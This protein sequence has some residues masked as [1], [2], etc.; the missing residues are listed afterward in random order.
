MR[1][2]KIFYLFIHERHNRERGRETGRGRS[3]LHAWS[4]MRDSIPELLDHALS[5]KQTLNHW[6]T[7]VSLNMRYLLMVR[8]TDYIPQILLWKIWYIIPDW[9]YLVE[10]NFRLP[11]RKFTFH[12]CQ[13]LNHNVFYNTGQTIH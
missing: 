5:Q 7:Q 12:K 2:L 10:K 3:R 11:D 1:F 4:L 13:K 6:A 8:K 9:S